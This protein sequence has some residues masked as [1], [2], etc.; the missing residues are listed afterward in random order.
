M[1]LGPHLVW[2]RAAL[3]QVTPELAREVWSW[4]PTVFTL[5]DSSRATSLA[6]RPR[7]RTPSTSTS[8][9]VSPF[10]QTWRAQ[11]WTGRR[12]PIGG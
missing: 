12:P 10:G 11:P 8:R 2:Q 1:A 9:S 3:R 7:T 5:I 4:L 6:V